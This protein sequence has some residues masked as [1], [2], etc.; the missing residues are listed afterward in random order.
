[1]TT[2]SSVVLWSDLV[3]KWKIWIWKV[4]LFYFLKKEKR[5]DINPNILMAVL[6]HDSVAVAPDCSLS[7]SLSCDF[8]VEIDV[9]LRLPLQFVDECG[10]L[11]FFSVKARSSEIGN[12]NF[13]F[14]KPT[15][16]VSTSGTEA[17]LENCLAKVGCEL[18]WQVSL[19]GCKSV[20]S[21]F[22]EGGGERRCKVESLYNVQKIVFLIAV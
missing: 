2:V 3:T 1:M 13:T 11:F 12:Q 20:P 4:V 18:S 10:Y 9:M 15:S 22:V 21:W 8:S 16:A 7:V 17:S 6:F 14:L 5:C 19:F